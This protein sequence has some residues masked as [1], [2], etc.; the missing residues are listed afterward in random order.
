MCS[1]FQITFDSF[2]QRLQSALVSFFFSFIFPHLSLP[3]SL[4][5]FH[6]IKQFMRATR[7]TLLRNT[8]IHSFILEFKCSR[9][10]FVRRAFTVPSLRS[11]ISIG[12]ITGDREACSIRS[13]IIYNLIISFETNHLSTRHAIFTLHSRAWRVMLHYSCVY[14]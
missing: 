6:F 8:F 1:R 13:I 3:P 4:P 2:P 10:L 9:F 14:L 12:R 11:S 5:S 7:H